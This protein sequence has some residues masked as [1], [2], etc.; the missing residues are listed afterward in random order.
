[1][2]VLIVKRGALGDVVRT[3]YFARALKQKFSGKVHITWWT[4][5]SA[6]PLLRFNPFVDKIVTSFDDLASARYDRIYSL[7]DER[8]TLEGVAALDS[9]RIT[10]AYL[11]GDRPTY[12]SDSAAWFDMGLLSRFGKE[13]ADQFK[14][15]N[16]RGHAEIFCEIFGVDHVEP[17]FYGDPHEERWARGWL[18]EGH[19]AVA[20]NPFAGGRWPSKELR[21]SA[22][23][24]LIATL[25]T[26]RSP[27]GKPVRVL[28]LGAGADRA[29]NLAF[30]AQFASK[31]IGVANTDASP[32]RLAAVIGCADMLIS[33]DRGYF[34]QY[35]FVDQGRH[36]PIEIACTVAP[37]RRACRAAVAP[38]P[39]ARVPCARAASHG[40][41]EVRRLG[42]SSRRRAAR[43]TGPR[44]SGR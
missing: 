22:L 26:Q 12:T 16:R 6:E 11:D 9:A 20:I 30:A 41:A 24:E 34:Y 3:S 4:A 14:K 39:I 35:L 29:R 8:E 25:L 18:G 43:N 17:A 23:H 42:W 13:R 7:D 10:G 5:R 28:L 2:R 19:F 32:L 36:V 33:N 15:E 38:A 40:A 31:P 44:S 1:M 21:E 27:N 37:P